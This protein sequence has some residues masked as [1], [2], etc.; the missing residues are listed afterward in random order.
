MSILIRRHYPD[1]LADGLL[2]LKYEYSNAKWNRYEA[3]IEPRLTLIV[4]VF[5]LVML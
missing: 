3:A 5:L 2:I 1:R 4:R